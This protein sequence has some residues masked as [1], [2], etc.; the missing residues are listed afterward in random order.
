M[1]D[2]ANNVTVCGLQKKSN[3]ISSTGRSLTDIN[4]SSWGAKR[5]DSGAPSVR[6]FFSM[7]TIVVVHFVSRCIVV[8]FSLNARE[9]YLYLI[10]TLILVRQCGAQ[11]KN[12]LDF[13]VLK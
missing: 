9:R 6:D 5:A 1:I 8:F 10:E 3:E 12:V 13:R 4:G 7:A 11:R 2:T